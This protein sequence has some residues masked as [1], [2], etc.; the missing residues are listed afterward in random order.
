[1]NAP[2]GHSWHP[3]TGRLFRLVIDQLQC[4]M[5][6]LTIHDTH[7]A[8]YDIVD[9]FNMPDY[10]ANRLAIDIDKS[11]QV[12][13]W[14]PEKS[15]QAV[16][17][18]YEGDNGQDRLCGLTYYCRADPTVLLALSVCWQD[19]SAPDEW[20]DRREAIDAW[21]DAHLRLLWRSHRDR[22]RVGSLEHTLNLF[23]FTV[24]VLAADGNILFANEQAHALLDIGDGLRRAGHSIT[25]TDFDD[26]V[27]LQTAIQ[28]LS[29]SDEQTKSTD[30]GVATVLLL[31]RANARPL[32]ASLARMPPTARGSAATVLHVIDPDG[33]TRPLVGE[34]CRAFGLTPTE[35]TLA[36]HLVE[37][38]TI[39]GAAQA[40]RIQR[41]T[42]RAYLKQVFVKTDTH[43]QADLVRVILNGIVPIKA[44]LSLP[45]NG[46]NGSARS[47]AK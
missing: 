14:I 42:A 24:I 29:H 47:G 10:L 37:G 35:A 26:A 12:D 19:G 34:L 28:H 32:V 33:E 21:V 2:N 9:M 6:T 3:E 41:Q 25:A 27:R 23:D 8:E 46:G 40:M 20:R 30:T 7:H 5:C 15:N 22:G 31:R 39:D 1:M 44:S 4:T 45:A 38:L 18:D 43:R 11:I 17:F 16:S 36:H 13:A